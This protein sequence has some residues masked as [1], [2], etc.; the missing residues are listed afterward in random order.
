MTKPATGKSNGFVWKARDMKSNTFSP[1]AI[2]NL[3]SL[4]SNRATSFRRYADA[5]GTEIELVDRLLQGHLAGVP[6]MQAELITA[7]RRLSALVE[8]GGPQNV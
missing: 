8:T 2:S 4:A 3:R 5:L 6:D 1:E 7:G